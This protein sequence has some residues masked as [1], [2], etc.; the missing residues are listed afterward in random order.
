MCC[1]EF[2]F[3]LFRSVCHLLKQVCLRVDAACVSVIFIVVEVASLSTLYKEMPIPGIILALAVC[4]VVV[5][6][7]M[8]VY[9]RRIPPYGRLI[10][11][12]SAHL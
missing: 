12:V 3:Y 10:R 11:V 4:A 1:R 9:V 7:C 5:V 6:M 2:L 8:C